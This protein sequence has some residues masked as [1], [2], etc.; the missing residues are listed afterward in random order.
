[1]VSWTEGGALIRREDGT[2]LVVPRNR[3]YV[4][5]R[6]EATIEREEK[7]LNPP[8][9]R[10]PAPKTKLTREA[11]GN[12]VNL[13]DDLHARIFDYGMDYVA[14]KR[15]FG[16]STFEMDSRH[17]PARKALAQELGV[18]EQSLDKL[19]D[20]YRY[21]VLNT[22]KQSGGNLPVG[23]HKIPPKLLERAQKD[24]KKHAE[25]EEVIN[26]PQQANAG[27][28][29]EKKEQIAEQKLE[30][31]EKN[32]AKT[33]S[34]EDKTANKKEKIEE[35]KKNKPAEK[36][37]DEHYARL[38]NATGPTARQAILDKAKVVHSAKLDWDR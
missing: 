33:K 28:I 38:W 10:E 19:A 7:K 35:K 18:S 5:G 36:Q 25:Q 30:G 34:N 15:L 9:E 20:D 14:S 16:K 13:P 4:D 23:M 1:V 2:E 24:F 21:R 12:Q 31:K 11:F 3:L 6:D 26:Q 32:Q 8:V 27:K 17:N 37:S 29:K 22:A